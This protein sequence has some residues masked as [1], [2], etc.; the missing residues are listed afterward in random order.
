MINELPLYKQALRETLD[1]ANNLELK[2]NDYQKRLI[3]INNLVGFS[4]RI[5]LKIKNDILKLC[6]I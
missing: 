2:S 3:A 4:N 1:K 5:P 6:R